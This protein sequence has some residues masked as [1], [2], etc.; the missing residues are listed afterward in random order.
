M[1]H[2]AD[3]DP[4]D[5][6]TPTTSRPTPRVSLP[7]L[8]LCGALALAAG[9]CD[10]D[11]VTGTAPPIIDLMATAGALQESTTYTVPGTGEERTLPLTIWYPTLDT[12]GTTTRFNPIQRDGLS[13]LNASVAAP[14]RPAPL[15]VYSH[16]DRAWGGSAHRLARQFVNNGWIVVAADHIGSTLLENYDPRPGEYEIVRAYDV[17]AVIDYMENLPPEHPLHGLVR[18]D[19]V[20]LTG[21]SYGGRT[22]WLSSGVTLDM[23]AIAADCAGCTQG[24][25]DAF[26]LYRPDERII[27]IAPFAGDLRTNRASAAGYATVEMP[28]LFM[29]GTNDG[30]GGMPMFERAALADV[31]WIQFQGGCH[32]SFT[33][34]L[35]CD[36]LDL[37]ASVEATATYLI[38]FGEVHVRHS[39][40]PAMQAIVDGTTEVASF[41]TYQHSPTRRP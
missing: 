32:E 40:N 6:S 1:R 2:N 23:D 31:T 3:E 26:A 29:T 18:T 36:T 5:H 30:D 13:F 35:T 24:Q 11:S 16:G 27:A 9:A 34:T 33:G 39:S 20:Y 41:A 12:S 10:D 17:Q 19:E 15:M 38:A 25:L 4:M 37:D 14:R 7:L 8:G 21:H 22:A 28:V